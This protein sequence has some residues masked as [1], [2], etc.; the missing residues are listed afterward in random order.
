MSSP[1]LLSAKI[2]S[3]FCDCPDIEKKIYVTWKNKRI[4]DKSYSI[5]K[6]GIVQLKKL[7]PDYM[8]YIYDDAEVDEYIKSKVSTADYELIRTRNIVEKADLWR[9][10]VMYWEGGVYCD[11]DRF[12]NQPLSTIITAGVK[13]VLPIYGDTDFSQD[14]MMSCKGNPIVARAIELNLERRLTTINDIF[15]LG[16]ATYFNAATEVLLGRQLERY[17]GQEVLGLLEAGIKGSNYMK[18]YVERPPFDTIL[19]RGSALLNDKSRMYREEAVQ[20]WSR[21]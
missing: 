19:Y 12:C 21:A 10:L 17:P 2:D 3:L 14:I 18:T 8:F 6:N 13:C 15:Y 4:I 16:P 5:I 1:S 7:N 9:L 11:I 20:H